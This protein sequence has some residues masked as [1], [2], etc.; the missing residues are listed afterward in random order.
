MSRV[1]KPIDN[2]LAI[3]MLS[4]MDGH[5]T[6]LYSETF[7]AFIDAVLKAVNHPAL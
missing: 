5:K 6:V 2:A 7:R 1:N 3:H 4:R